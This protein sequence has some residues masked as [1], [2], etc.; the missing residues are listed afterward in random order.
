MNIF[1]SDT[2]PTFSIQEYG[3]NKIYKGIHQTIQIILF[4]RL[5]SDSEPWL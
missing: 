1:Y 3:N 5:I 4:L 2:Y